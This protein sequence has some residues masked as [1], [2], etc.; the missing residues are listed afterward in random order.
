MISQRPYRPSTDFSE[1]MSLDLRPNDKVELI[2]NGYMDVPTAIYESIESSTEVSVIHIEG[3]GIAGV[4][5]VASCPGVISVP[6]M[7]AEKH[8]EGEY[9]RIFARQSRRVVERWSETYGKLTQ[10]VWEGHAAALRWLE[11]LGFEYHKTDVC[12]DGMIN[13]KTLIK[14][15]R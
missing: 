2:G 15:V 5:G 4:F 14:E 7:L 6:W 10:N 9:S 8:I 11:W 1:T 3:Y 12:H 13:Y